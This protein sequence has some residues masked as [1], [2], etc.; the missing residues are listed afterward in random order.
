M[1]PDGKDP[2]FKL[3]S[4]RECRAILLLIP[5]LGALSFIVY[6]ASQP[7]FEDNFT[8]YAD[9]VSFSRSETKPDASTQ[10]RDSTAL[11]AFDPNTIEFHDLCRL[12][13]S[14]SQALSIIKFR[15]AGKTFSIPE[16]LAAC[17]A[18]SESMYRA[19]LPYIRISPRYALRRRA[20]SPHT[21]NDTAVR[22]AEL[23][24]FVP[25]TVSA[26]VFQ[27]LGFSPAQAQVIIKY[28]TARGGFDSEED[29][30]RCYA[31]S[32][33]M[34]ERLRPYMI[35]PAGDTASADAGPSKVELNTADSASLLSVY[36][37]GPKTAG[38]II[39]YRRRLGGFYCAEQMAEIPG[40][41]ERNFERIC[42]QIFID[43]C[44]IR[45]I[46]INFA[47]AKE[48]KGHPYISPATLRKLLKRRQL[49]GGWHSLEDLLNDNIFN[50][51][52]AKRI[53][54]YLVFRDENRSSRSN[55]N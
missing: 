5:V 47:P 9:A 30:A 34:L 17:Y 54:P 6:R 26:E 24:E 10:K 29:F 45:K 49:K 3:F 46:D 25:D 4:T 35:F 51:Q 36:G 38:G 48:L 31:I 14:R 33:R 27:R 43:T 21:D 44:K 18:V 53:A 8:A 11:F 32:E 2:S 40:M 55:F 41:N 1:K 16:D 13:F 15:A 12:G 23:F 37:I 19:L 50:P 39:E 42:K 22:S 52:E 20:A 28:R 7:R